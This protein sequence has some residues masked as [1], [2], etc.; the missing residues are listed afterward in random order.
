MPFFSI[1]IPCY[2]QGAWLADTIP[3]IQHQSF[4]D[5]EVIIVDDGSTD[6]TPSLADEWEKKD[7]R[8][9]VVHQLNGGL[10]AA[11]NGGLEHATGKWLDFLD[12]DDYLLPGC[13]QKVADKINEFNDVKIIQTGYQLV[14]ENKKLISD[15][16]PAGDGLIIDIVLKGNLGPCQSVFIEKEFASGLGIFDTTLRSAEDW[17]FWLRAGK[18]GATRAIITE[19]LEA[20]RQ[21]HT[22]MSRSPW[23]MYANTLKVIERIGKKDERIKIVSD[24]NKDRAVDTSKAIQH[25]LLQCL[26]LTIMQGNVNEALQY[27]RNE[28]EKY[29]LKYSPAD[30]GTM[31]SF[32]SFRH[33]YR[34]EDVEK[35]LKDYPHLFAEFFSKTT[36]SKAFQN[37]AMKSVFEFHQKNKNIYKFGPFGRIINK[38]SGMGSSTHEPEK[39]Y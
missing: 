27:F 22:S 31:N 11:R 35:V 37:A 8:I 20:Y 16:K 28:S 32:L 14:D 24:L 29:K 36:F 6:D 13:L 10:S 26:G 15:K 7:K 21:L 34:K 38:I 2:N 1:I 39:G 30:F 17:D 18:A 12:A 33:W 9:I 3:S 4:T 23:T 19:P 5:W 25:R